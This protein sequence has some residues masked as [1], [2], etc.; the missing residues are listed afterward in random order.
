L[1][2]FE[3]GLHAEQ[4]HH[5][6]MP[7][8]INN[9]FHTGYDMQ[10]TSASSSRP[11]ATFTANPTWRWRTITIPQHLHTA[12]G[13]QV[14]TVCRICYQAGKSMKGCLHPTNKCNEL[15]SE[16]GKQVLNFLQQ[17]PELDHT[18]RSSRVTPVPGN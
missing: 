4:N 1:I 7:Y 8:P 2:N 17:H 18:T 5:L 16:F 12:Y 10:Q 9:V 14:E 15:Q 13:T 3:D 6:V 11:L